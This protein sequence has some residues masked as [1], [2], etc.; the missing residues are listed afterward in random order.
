M[1]PEGGTNDKPVGTVWVAVV[2]DEGIKTKKF[3]FRFERIKNI[4]LTALNALNLLR[5]LIVDKG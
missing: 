4:Q 1:G 2:G 5:E 3:T